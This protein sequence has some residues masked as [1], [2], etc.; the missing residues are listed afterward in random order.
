MRL[1][2]SDWLGVAVAAET[3]RMFSLAA[4]AYERSMLFTDPDTERDR[5]KMYI[6]NKGAFRHLEVMRSETKE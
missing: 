2:H 4:D 3:R 6:E 5:H 1:S